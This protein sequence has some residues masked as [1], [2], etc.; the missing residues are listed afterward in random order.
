MLKNDTLKNGTSRLCLY[1]SAP[2]PGLDCMGP[3]LTVISHCSRNVSRLRDCT[4]LSRVGGWKYLQ[5]VVKNVL[6]PSE[7]HDKKIFAPYTTAAKK[8]C[9]PYAKEIFPLSQWQSIII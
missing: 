6:A 1:E 7:K 4:L 5:K 2:P 8:V 3:A 9:V